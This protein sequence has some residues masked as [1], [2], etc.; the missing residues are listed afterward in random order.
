MRRLSSRSSVSGAGQTHPRSAW[1]SHR[2]MANDGGYI[3]GEGVDR[4]D[5]IVVT[6]FADS[7]AR[8]A[9]ENDPDFK[10]AAEIRDKAAKLVSISGKSVFRD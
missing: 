4:P 7:S 5:Q 2:A 9:F 3:E 8:E 10:R 1:R 6:W